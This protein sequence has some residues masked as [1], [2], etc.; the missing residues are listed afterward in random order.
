MLQAYIYFSQDRTC[1]TKIEKAE[2]VNGYAV[3]KDATGVIF[4]GHVVNI[5]LGSR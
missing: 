2:L 3:V 1:T 5:Q 4:Q